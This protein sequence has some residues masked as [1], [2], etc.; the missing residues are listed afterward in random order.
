M[1]SFA[2]VRVAGNEGLR[3]GQCSPDEVLYW[4]SG[5]LDKRVNTKE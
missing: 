4:H 2:G 1:A 3:L 5:C